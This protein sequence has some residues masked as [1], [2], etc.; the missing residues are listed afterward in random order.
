M[1][2]NYKIV[3]CLFLLR[4]MFPSKVEFVEITA[5]IKETS[6]KYKNKNTDEITH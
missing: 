2:K 5:K 4:L 1:N 6:G 3:P